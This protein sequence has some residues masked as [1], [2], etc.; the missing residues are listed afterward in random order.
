VIRPLKV[1]I[2]ALEPSA[3]N[4]GAGLMRAL[5]SQTNAPIAFVGLGGPAMAEA[6]LA[7]ALS[8]AGMAIFG[9]DAVGKLLGAWNRV[10][11]VARLAAREQPDAAVLIDSWGFN[12]LLAWRLRGRVPAMKRIKY[13]AP[14]VWAS[15][16]WRART[17][18]KAVDHVLA[19]HSFEP[20]Y[21]EREGL[22]TTFV[23]N[24]V[25]AAGA[26]PVSAAEARAALGLAADDQ[27]LLI[28]P[29][30]RPGEIRTLAP[31]F[32][33][34]VARLMPGR[35]HLKLALPVAEAVADQ[36]RRAVAGWR[37]PVILIEGESARRDAMKAAT[38]ALAKSGTVTTELALAGVPMVVAYR[39]PFFTSLIVRAVIR[40]PYVSFVNI[41]AG[42][43]IAPEFL[44]ENCTAQNLAAALAARLDD[45]ALRERQIAD[46]NAALDAM[47]RSVGDPS[48]R[49]AEAVLKV[50]GAG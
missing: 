36:V 21:F 31:I 40:T 33:Q 24:P 38:L 10:E 50:I 11:D 19:I 8:N 45:P 1:L 18:A 4:L 6:G 20:P 16:S 13:V 22:A 28:L 7:S 44:Q 12:I 47:G 39:F 41:V 2:V 35:P 27:L 29:G 9:L 17:L 49:A 5:K 32:E 15:R 48:A 46:Q 25:L 37:Y 26:S 14:Q 30:S 42:R 3:D 23:G 43:A 34:A